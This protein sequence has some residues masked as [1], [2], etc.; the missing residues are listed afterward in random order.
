[1]IRGMR[2]MLSV[3]CG[4]TIAA[5]CWLGAMFVVLHRA[6]YQRGV[7]ISA[8]LLLQSLLTLGVAAKILAS[9][10]ARTA[11]ILGAASIVWLGGAAINRNL[12]GPHFEGYAVVVGAAL[13]VQGLL[14]IGLFASGS[15]ALWD[16]VRQFVN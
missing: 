4:L 3:L 16:K 2:A 6:G 5:S 15:P 10:W 1:M 13:V 9:E 12:S 11:A 7:A 14:T 8:L